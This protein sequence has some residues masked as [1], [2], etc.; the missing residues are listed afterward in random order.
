MTR[1]S[2]IKF[3]EV[4]PIRYGE[5][6][7]PENFIKKMTWVSSNY[8]IWPIIETQNLVGLENSFAFKQERH[9]KLQ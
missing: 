7:N 3:F 1:K 9:F 4:V 6:L 8:C 2:D 5:S